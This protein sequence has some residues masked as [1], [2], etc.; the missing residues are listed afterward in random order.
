MLHCRFRRPTPGS[1]C[2]S[3]SRRK[4]HPVISRRQFLQYCQGASFAFLPSGLLYPSL[5]S[6]FSQEKSNL[7]YELQL[8]PRYRL[9][10]GI[11]SV[12]RKVP[13]AF[14][15]FVTEKYQ[16]Q[17]SA[18]LSEWSAELLESPQ[19][20]T[21]LRRAVAP[22]FTANSLRSR[23]PQVV[24]DA[25]PLTVWKIHYPQ[26]ANTGKEGYLAEMLEWLKAIWILVA[27]ADFH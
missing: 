24:T 3:R 15:E 27:N 20:T 18:I 7:P 16:D 4:P 19:D 9:K 6:V 8:H 26:E 10:R 5:Q 12:L 11:E 25:A 13:A 14:D 2:L 1:D 21:A 17:V 23:Q 22:S